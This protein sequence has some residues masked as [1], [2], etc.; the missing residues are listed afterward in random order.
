MMSSFSLSEYVKNNFDGMLVFADVHGDFES[1]MRAYDYAK[2]ENYFFMSLGDLVDRADKPYEVVTTMSDIVYNGRGG[3]VVG[4]HDNKYAKLHQGKS[5]RLSKD[6]AN[7]MASVGEERRQH[8]LDMYVRMMS[9]TMMSG[10]FHTFD[11]ITLV[12]GAGHPDMWSTTGKFGSS[13]QSRALYGQTNGDTNTDGYPV[14]LYDWIEE[15]PTGKTVMV[16][17]DR[18][19]VFNRPMTVPLVIKNLHGGQAIFLD[20]GCGKGGFLS[21][22]VILHG[23]KSFKFDKF[24]EFK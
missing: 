9:D 20:T 23:K 6:G 17:H 4:N 15:V 11:D 16:G 18:T 14:R 3:M 19:P 13:A 10:M 7:T 8:F 12:H 24:V 22:A 5:V 2:S 1:F 21:G